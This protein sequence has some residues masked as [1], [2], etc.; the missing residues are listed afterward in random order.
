MT[1]LGLLAQSPSQESMRYGAPHL[2]LGVRGERREL[3]WWPSRDASAVP[4]A[5][6]TSAY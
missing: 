6:V 1:D 5:A 3:G 4:V 2:Q